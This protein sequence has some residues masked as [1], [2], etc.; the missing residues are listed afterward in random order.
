MSALGH[1]RKFALRATAQKLRDLDYNH[2]LLENEL[3][4]RGMIRE[5][6]GRLGFRLLAKEFERH[7]SLDL[8]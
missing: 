2:Y 5:R 3:M 4:S 8:T 7:E 1:K 6:T